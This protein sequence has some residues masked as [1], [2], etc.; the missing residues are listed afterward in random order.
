MAANVAVVLVD[1]TV[2][3]VGVVNAVVVSDSATVAPPVFETVTVH[4]ALPPD[5]RL[6]G[7]HVNPSSATGA[8]RAI[9][10][11]RELPFRVAVIVAV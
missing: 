5:P 4:V 6:V 11:V 8:T 10:A 7:L 1:P 3:E 2:T 9:V